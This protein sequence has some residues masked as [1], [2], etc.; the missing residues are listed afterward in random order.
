MHWFKHFLSKKL[1]I[2]DP[3][4]HKIGHIFS[5]VWLTELV[6]VS[7]CRASGP[8]LLKIPIQYFFCIF[9]VFFNQFR[10]KLGYFEGYHSKLHPL[11]YPYHH[12]IN[13]RSVSKIIF[14]DSLGVYWSHITVKTMIWRCLISEG[15]ST[16]VPSMDLLSLLLLINILQ[17]TP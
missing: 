4:W 15:M 2:F 14:F 6:L 10:S 12:P 3:R 1:A 5:T 11:L 9:Y 8:L 16:F 7:K 13:Y 17:L